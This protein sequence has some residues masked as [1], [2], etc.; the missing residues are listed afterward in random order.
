MTRSARHLVTVYPTLAASALPSL[1]TRWHSWFP[2]SAP[3]G[4]WTFSGRVALYHGLQTLNLAAGSVILVPN[5][6]QGVEIDTLLAAGHQL[7]YYRVDER[8]EIDLRDV[9]RQMDH[10]VSALYVIHYFGFSQPVTAVR[11]FCDEHRLTLIEDCA[12]SLFSQQDGHWLGTAGDM[13]LYSVY[14]TLPLPHGGFLVTRGERQAPPLGAAPLGST[15]VQ[16]LDLVHQT[17]KATGRA[18]IERCM[19][20]ASRAVR[21]LLGWNR[22]QTIESGGARWDPRILGHAASRCVTG[23]MRLVDRERVIMR[24]RANFTR[25]AAHL[26]G[27]IPCPFVELPPGVC[28]LFFPVLVPDKRR[29]QQDLAS[30]GVESVNLWDAPHPSCPRSVAADV[31]HWREHCLELPIHQELSDRAIDRVADAVSSVWDRHHARI[32][33]HATGPARTHRAT[34]A[35]KSR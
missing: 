15:L 33:H 17:L 35:M 20:R 27:H 21:R 29:F 11:A 3:H 16:T 24:R 19:T 28:P 8:L 5:Y 18:G 7:R 10:R 12:L 6:H 2:F 23:L 22:A 32:A 14:K 1:S 34:A 30:R 31:S 4:V 9:E 26:K 13:A 25:L